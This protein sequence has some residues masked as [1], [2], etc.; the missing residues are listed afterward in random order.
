MKALYHRWQFVHKTKNGKNYYNQNWKVIGY[1][2]P[3]C[4][5]SFIYHNN[6]LTK[7]FVHS[8]PREKRSK[9]DPKFKYYRN[10]YNSRFKN[11]ER[12][13]STRKIKSKTK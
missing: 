7:G 2:C 11:W 12:H 1:Y 4:Y 13:R 9:F 5:R 8:L 10:T 3:Y 6:P